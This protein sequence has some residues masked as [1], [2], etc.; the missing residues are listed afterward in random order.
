MENMTVITSLVHKRYKAHEMDSQWSL[1]LTQKFIAKCLA[2]VV[3]IGLVIS[4]H[5]I[6]DSG[7]D[8]W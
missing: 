5:L 4:R 1:I 8:Q 7:I 2:T 3:P 6:W